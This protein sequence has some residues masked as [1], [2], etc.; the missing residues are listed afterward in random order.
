MGQMTIFRIY[1]P[2]KKKYHFIVL[3][4]LIQ[5]GKYKRTGRVEIEKRTLKKKK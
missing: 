4:L 2:P 5:L 1:N 3:G